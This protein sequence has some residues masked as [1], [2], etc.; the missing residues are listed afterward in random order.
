MIRYFSFCFNHFKSQFWY[1][2]YV[3]IAG[4]L[5]IASQQYQPLLSDCENQEFNLSNIS[6]ISEEILID[7]Q[8]K[9]SFKPL[10]PQ[11]FQ[12]Q[13]PLSPYEK[14]RIY[15]KSTKKLNKMILKFGTM[16]SVSQ[17]WPVL[18]VTIS[19]R[20]AANNLYLNPNKW[21][22]QA[23]WVRSLIKDIRQQQLSPNASVRLNSLTK[24]SKKSSMSFLDMIRQLPFESFEEKKNRVLRDVEL[25][26]LNGLIFREHH[27]VGKSD[28]ARFINDYYFIL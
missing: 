2:L 21:L 25:I 26:I 27:S 4:D 13:A 24:K 10:E 1:L 3:A 9:Q 7:A 15:Q 12:K 22:S 6:E 8:D 11:Y 19:S 28:L 14:E 16:V 23:I 20:K 17:A 5:A 18:L